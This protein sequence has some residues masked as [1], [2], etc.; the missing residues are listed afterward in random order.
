[1]TRRNQYSQETGER[2]NVHHYKFR[3]FHFDDFVNF[4]EIVNNILSLNFLQSVSAWSRRGQN[5]GDVVL[6]VLSVACVLTA[7]II[8]RLGNIFTSVKLSD[9][10]SA[11]RK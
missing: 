10:A 9:T 5:I 11:K 1:M 2:F 6:A 8:S 4:T 7:Q 3:T